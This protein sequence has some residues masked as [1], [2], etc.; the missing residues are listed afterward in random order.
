MFVP[1]E[2]CLSAAFEEDPELLEYAFKQ[3]V[4]PT[5]PVTLL[6]LLKAVAYGWQ[7]QRVTEN[8]RQIAEQGK[9]M[10][11][12]LLKFLDFLHKTGKGLESTVKTYNEGVASLEG[13]LLPSARRFQEL[14]AMADDLPPVEPIERQVR[15]PELVKTAGLDGG[16]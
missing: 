3:R 8:A 2:A 6:A 5:T 7:Q 14:S 11:A 12:R 4:L 10:Y 16:S 15:M 1:N 13:R 9:E